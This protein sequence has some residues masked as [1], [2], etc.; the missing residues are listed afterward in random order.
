M[1]ENFGDW[2]K[3]GEN[4][5]RAGEN[6]VRAGEDTQCDALRPPNLQR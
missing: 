4:G 1:G 6:R 5:V 2:G 3:R